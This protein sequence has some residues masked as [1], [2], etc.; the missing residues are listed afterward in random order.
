MV[1]QAEKATAAKCKSVVVR[2]GIMSPSFSVLKEGGSGGVNG[3]KL[4]H[5]ME[6]RNGAHARRS[7]SFCA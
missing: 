4:M 1:K 5:E 6:P 7:E 3:E 2:K